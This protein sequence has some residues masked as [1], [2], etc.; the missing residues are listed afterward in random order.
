[1]V[2]KA[3]ILAFGLALGLGVAPS[4]ASCPD[5][6]PDTPTEFAQADRVIVGWVSE[7]RTIMDPDDPYAV[8]A[9]EFVVQTLN[10]YK[11]E[12][13]TSF[14][15]Y[16]SNDSGRFDMEFR[17][18]YL[19]FLTDLGGRWGVSNCGNSFDLEWTD[20]VYS[21]KRPGW[22]FDEVMAY[23]P[24]A[25]AALDGEVQRRV[26]LQSRSSEGGGVE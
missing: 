11:G 21:P 20:A 6:W 9:T 13:A 24:Q 19:L 26:A 16:N 25:E 8:L 2:L 14:T 1:M 22:T 17:H 5:G 3:A 4:G 18:S 23:R 7:A 12:P 15:I 10:T